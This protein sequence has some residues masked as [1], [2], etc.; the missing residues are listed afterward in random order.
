[1]QG[2]GRAFAGTLRANDADLTDGQKVAELEVARAYP[3]TALEQA[4]RRLILDD[5]RDVLWLEDTFQFADDAHQVDDVLVT[6]LPVSLDGDTAIVH[7][8]HRQVRLSIEAPT[9]ATFSLESLGK[10]SRFDDRTAVLQRIR[11]WASGRVVRV[12]VRVDVMLPGSEG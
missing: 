12:L 6:W 9:E 7:G 8:R 2:T 3:V 5:R 1:M 10:E 4:R 11:L